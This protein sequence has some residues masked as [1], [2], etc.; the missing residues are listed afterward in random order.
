[1]VFFVFIRINLPRWFISVFTRKNPMCSIYS[2]GIY[3]EGYI[4]FR[5]YICMVVH[6]FCSHHICGISDNVLVK[7]F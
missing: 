5:H 4:V 6:F 3:V 2:P 1:M 7:L